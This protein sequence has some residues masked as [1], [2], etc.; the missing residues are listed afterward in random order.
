LFIRNTL[1]RKPKSTLGFFLFSCSFFIKSR[2]CLLPLMTPV[3]TALV[4][5][6]EFCHFFPSIFPSHPNTHKY[7]FILHR[8]KPT[9]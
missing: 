2:N 9:T 4:A 5:I 7:E 3:M 1:Q 8:N 6:Y